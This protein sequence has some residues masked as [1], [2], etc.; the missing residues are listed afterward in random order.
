MGCE[1]EGREVSQFTT[2]NKKAR[3]PVKDSGPFFY[4]DKPNVYS[5]TDAADRPYS[6][7]VSVPCFSG[8]TQTLGSRPDEVRNS[9]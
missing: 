5:A 9:M 2:Q 7:F 3:F 8:V 6:E 4:E 1:E